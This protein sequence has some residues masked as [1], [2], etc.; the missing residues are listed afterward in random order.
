MFVLDFLPIEEGGLKDSVAI[1]TAGWAMKFIPLLG[2]ALK[3]MVIDGHSPYILDEFSITRVNP[4][5]VSSILSAGPGPAH[6]VRAKGS[7][8]VKNKGSFFYAQIENE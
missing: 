4:A 2:K 6:D 7:R 5:T 8:S 1:F 3:E